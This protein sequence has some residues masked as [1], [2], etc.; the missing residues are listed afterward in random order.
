MPSTAA[1]TADRSANH[2]AT[3]AANDAVLVSGAAG[4]GLALAGSARGTAGTVPVAPGMAVMTPTARA[5]KVKQVVADSSGQVRSLVVRA[6]KTDLTLPATGVAA[7]GSGK[8]LIALDGSTPGNGTAQGDTAGAERSGWRKDGG[9]RWAADPNFHH[10][11]RAAD[12]RL[13]ALFVF[14][15]GIIPTRSCRAASRCSHRPH[16]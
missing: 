15:Q 7:N 16:G 11:K 12:C 2:L 9:R 1:R 10:E 5:R 3:G 13:A 8:G 14:G 4:R 6:G